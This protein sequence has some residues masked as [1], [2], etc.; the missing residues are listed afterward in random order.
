MAQ[1]QINTVSNALDHETPPEHGL[2]A[3]KGGTD[4]DREDMLR[5]GKTQELKRNF[6]L[7]TIFS[8]TMVAMATWEAQLVRLA[9]VY[10]RSYHTCANNSRTRTYSASSMVEQRV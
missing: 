3:E 8:F 6:Q 5:M 9:A 10:M 2:L 4:H 7:Y 1:N